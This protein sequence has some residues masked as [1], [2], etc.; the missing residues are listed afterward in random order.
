MRQSD[1]NF[2]VFSLNLQGY[3]REYIQ[4]S[5]LCVDNINNPA[6]CTKALARARVGAF[7]SPDQAAMDKWMDLSKP[8]SKPAHQTMKQG[9]S[10]SGL[11]GLIKPL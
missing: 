9:H 5:L 3:A 1:T 7:V 8:S 4:L 2:V 10:S 11:P 6:E